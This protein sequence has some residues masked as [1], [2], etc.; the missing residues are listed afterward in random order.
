MV[1]VMAMMGVMMLTL[2]DV[3]L[4]KMKLDNKPL[5]MAWLMSYP[6]SG[7]TYTLALVSDLTQ[8]HTASVY[9]KE[10][11]RS[12]GEPLVPVFPDDPVSPY[13]VQSSNPNATFPTRYVLTKTHCGNRKNHV[14]PEPFLKGC[15]TTMVTAGPGH[16]HMGPHSVEPLRKAIHLIRD[17]FDNIVSRF[18]F[19]RRHP[20]YSSYEATPEGFREFCEN[21]DYDRTLDLELDLYREQWEMLKDVPCR[22]ELIRYLQWHN[23]AFRT[24]RTL[25]LETMVL[26]YDS[27][28]TDFDGTVERILN[29][30]ELPKRASPTPFID[31]KVYSD[32]FTAKEKRLVKKVYDSMASTEAKKE[33]D[34]Y[35]QSIS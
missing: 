23:M 28:T 20:E 12:G 26:H 22:M 30:L 34:V 14:A 9:S 15:R 29:F 1:Q 27:Y 33:L 8:T 11:E 18:R 16:R 7:T 19:E 24:T 6:N 17:P 25:G 21:H 3:E 35:F 32:Y 2:N 13:W 31:G 4:P 10:S 5:E